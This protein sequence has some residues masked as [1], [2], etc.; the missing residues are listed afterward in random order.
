MFHRSH[1]N[2]SSKRTFTTRFMVVL[3][4]VAA[5]WVDTQTATVQDEIDARVLTLSDA[6]AAEPSLQDGFDLAQDQ[7]IIDQLAADL[8]DQLRETSYARSSMFGATFLLGQSPLDELGDYSFTTLEYNATLLEASDTVAELQ[9]GLSIAA[10]V[11]TLTAGTMAGDPVS[12]IGGVFGLVSNAIGIA[13]NAG[14][15]GN[16]PSVDEQIYAQL[17]ELRQQVE[18][19]RAEMNVRFDRIE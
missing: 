15:F 17:I 5:G 12:A 1:I 8:R 14:A 16:T 13:D 18:A 10:N 19:M 9:V 2:A 6:L 7:S 11:A 3:G 4:W